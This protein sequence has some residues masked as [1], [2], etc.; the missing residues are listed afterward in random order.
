MWHD[1]VLFETPDNYLVSLDAKTG[2]ERWHVEIADFNQQYFSTPPPIIIGNHVIVGTGNDLDGPGFLQSFDPETGKLQVEVLHGPM[3]P[4]DPGLETW[5]SLEAARNGGGHTW[6]P[7]PTIQRRT[8]TSSAP[9]IR[10]PAY[11]GVGRP[12]DNLFTCAL[13]AVDVETAR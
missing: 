4:G 1:S 2:E 5:P 7:A 12:G 13:I 11:T 9:A 3:K 6:F 8:C 10:R